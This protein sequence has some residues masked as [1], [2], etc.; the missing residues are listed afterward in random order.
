M[1]ETSK[2]EWTDATWNPVVGCDKVSPGCA[3]CYAESYAKRF[4]AAVPFDV[5]TLHPE[6]MD[7]PTR[8]TRPRKIFVGSLTDP[9]H[10]SIPTAYRDRMFLEM[11]LAGRHTFQVL[12]K[13]PDLA[14]DYLDG[15]TARPSMV[16]AA[17]NA[18]QAG[19]A[20]YA[21]FVPAVPTP[22]ALATFWPLSHV[23]IGTSV[24]NAHWA[25][26]RIPA[27]LTVPADIR[28]VSFEP[29]L[30][31]I[32]AGAILPGIDWAI[33]G[34]ESGPNTRPFDPDW[35]RTIFR[36]CHDLGIARFMKQL[37]G[38]PNKRD[39]MSHFPPDLQVREFPVIHWRTRKDSPCLDARTFTRPSAGLPGSGLKTNA[40]RTG[41]TWSKS[42]SKP[43]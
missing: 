34:G 22:D 5:I 29:L 1:S 19:G 12:T 18:A 16:G 8:W 15:L 25:D 32:P 7:W 27:L 20:I 2:I 23:W 11:I 31:P 37:G 10:T 41:T 38:W 28:F 24:E 13:R 4:R 3:N 40:K 43:R 30:G 17:L 9:F 6:R 42:N 14:R 35:A 33:V 26:K 21:D 39:R 36:T